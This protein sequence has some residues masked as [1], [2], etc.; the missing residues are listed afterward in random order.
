LRLARVVAI[1]TPTN[2]PSIA[3]LERLGFADEGEVRL[4]PDE[5]P[6]RLMAWSS[7]AG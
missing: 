1:V 4:P 2:R 3:L 6:L 7:P 5:E